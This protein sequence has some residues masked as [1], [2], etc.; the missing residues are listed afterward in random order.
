MAVS[1]GEWRDVT[2]GRWKRVWL[3]G[4]GFGGPA[5]RR[6]GRGRGG[7]RS[8]SGRRGDRWGR[9]RRARRGRRRSGGLFVGRRR[10]SGGLLVGRR[11][12][13]GRLPVGAPPAQRRAP[14]PCPP[15]ASPAGP[16]HG[17]SLPL[18]GFASAGAAVAGSRAW[19]VRRPAWRRPAPLAFST[20][21]RCRRLRLLRRG[22]R[23]AGGRLPRWRGA[24]AGVGLAGAGRAGVA[25]RP[26]TGG[27]VGTCGGVEAGCCGCPTTRPG[28]S[29]VPCS[30]RS[31][32]RP[33]H[34][35][36]RLTSRAC[37][38]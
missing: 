31:G 16:R 3:G 34:S 13:S 25:G 26:G 38:K 14:C 35:R 28:T 10:R 11:R 12:R 33:A 6:G 19:R 7:G 8:R 30:A 20:G 37:E 36:S 4:G 2:P 21:G 15:P 5:P 17:L 18:A 23:G 29:G 22:G 27:G 1:C 24:P 9:G 32:A